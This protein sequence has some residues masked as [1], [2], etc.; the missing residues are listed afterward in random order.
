[1][2]RNSGTF[3]SKTARFA[4]KKCHL[5]HLKRH[6]CH[7]RI[8]TPILIG[9]SLPLK[10]DPTSVRRALSTTESLVLFC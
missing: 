6:F 1:M 7:P 8:G 2:Q 10:H 3:G 5:T 9:F 4:L